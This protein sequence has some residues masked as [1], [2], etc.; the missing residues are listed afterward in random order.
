MI[1]KVCAGSFQRFVRRGDGIVRVARVRGN[2]Q[3]PYVSRDYRFHR[4]GGG[5]RAQPIVQNRS[6][7][8]N[9]QPH[10]HHHKEKDEITARH[11]SLSW[12]PTGRYHRHRF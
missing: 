8:G 3:V 12:Y 7:D 1:R 2:S 9:R 4:G 11:G 6:A 5:A 10:G